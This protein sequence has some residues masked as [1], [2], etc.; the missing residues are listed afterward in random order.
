M[1]N[2]NHSA[3]THK[4]VGRVPEQPERRAPAS[5][6]GQLIVGR[7]GEGQAGAADHRPA[8][9]RV[10]RPTTASRRSGD[11]VPGDLPGAAAT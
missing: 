2:H 1:Y 10:R 11:L 8:A 7:L 9:T 3:H 4:V 6:L 5:S